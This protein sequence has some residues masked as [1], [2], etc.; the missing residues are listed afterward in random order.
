MRFTYL[1]QPPKRYTFEQPKLKAW[2]EKQCRGKVLNLFAGR[3]LL[4]VNET[5]VDLDKAMPAQYHMDAGDFL[6]MAIEK[7]MKFDTVIL[8][9]P[10]NLRQSNEKYNGR[11]IGSFTKIKMQIPKILNPAGRVI[12]LGYSTVGYPKK[13][14][15]SKIAV[16]VVCHNGDHND[17]I[18][19]VEKQIPQKDLVAFTKLEVQNRD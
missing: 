1:R 16:C 13:M 8:D 12:T 7:D 10:Y 4:K 2:V 9:P 6:K 3:T 14:G 5:R 18:C 17:T 19:I 15:F 11:Y